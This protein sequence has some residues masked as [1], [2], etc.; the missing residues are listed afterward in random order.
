MIIYFN[1]LYGSNN[2]RVFNYVSHFDIFFSLILFIYGPYF[3]SRKLSK[4]HSLNYEL[5]QNHRLIYKSRELQDSDGYRLI[6]RLKKLL[7]KEQLF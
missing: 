3:N 4:L 6:I 1:F 2:K 5:I 7:N